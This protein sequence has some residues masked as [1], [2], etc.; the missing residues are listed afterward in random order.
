M[1]SHV[2]AIVSF[3][4]ILKLDLITCLPLEEV[5]SEKVS[6]LPEV[7]T[8]SELQGQDLELPVP[9]RTS[10]LHPSLCLQ[11]MCYISSRYRT[12]RVRR[13]DEGLAHLL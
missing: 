8:S 6:K 12:R 3:T 13:G 5:D 2:S 7:L 9:S 1:L 4:M 10:F 11:S